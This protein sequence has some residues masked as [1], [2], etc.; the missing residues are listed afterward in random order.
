MS[1]MFLQ[2]L[3]TCLC[4]RAWEIRKSPVVDMGLTAGLPLAFFKAG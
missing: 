1:Q 3:W 4:T 2:V